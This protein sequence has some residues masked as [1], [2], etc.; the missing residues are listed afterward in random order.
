MV[1]LAACLAPVAS[2]GSPAAGK[3]EGG[4]VLLVVGDSL[5]A[6]YG[7]PRGTGWVQLLADRLRDTG[8]DYRVVN[9]SI[10]GETTSGG[11]TRLPAL[12]KQHRPRILVLE[13][14]ANDGLRGLPLG[15][16]RDNLAA[17]IREAQSAGAQVLLVGVR[18]P[19]NYG[20]E[21]AERFAGTYAELAREFKV[22]LVPF[23]LDGF[24]ESLEL[25]QADRIHPTAEAQPRIL[26]NVWPVLRPM[27]VA[28][29]KR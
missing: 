16:M 27:L 3:G 2:W 12:L 24:A 1:V 28:R 13:L 20:R 10:S 14:G 6:E 29:P 22:R 17:M 4:P 19:P 21:Y 11:R 18:V 26:E 9:A 25:F 23:L 8:S 15:V 5:S 7:L